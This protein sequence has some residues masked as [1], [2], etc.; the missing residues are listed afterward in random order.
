MGGAQFR[1][2]WPEAVEHLVDPEVIALHQSREIDPTVPVA[3]QILKSKELLLLFWCGGP[4]E[5]SQSSV[6]GLEGS[7]MGC[8]G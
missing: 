8:I 5:P 3:Q 2:Q 6:P 7:G 1:S 4:A